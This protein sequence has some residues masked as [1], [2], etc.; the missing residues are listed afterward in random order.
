[1]SGEIFNGS[2]V[3]SFCYVVEMRM[4]VRMMKRKLTSL[5]L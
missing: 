3:F 5:F 2:S 1:M 4:K